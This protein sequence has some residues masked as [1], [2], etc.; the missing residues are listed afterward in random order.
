MTLQLQCRVFLLLVIKFTLKKK[1]QQSWYVKVVLVK[2]WC[3]SQTIEFIFGD[4][5]K[6]SRLV[7]EVKS[8]SHHSFSRVYIQFVLW[9]AV[10][11]ILVKRENLNLKRVECYIFFLE[12]KIG[13]RIFPFLALWELILFIHQTKKLKEHRRPE[14]QYLVKSGNTTQDR[15]VSLLLSPDVTEAFNIMPDPSFLHIALTSCLN[16][17]YCTL[18][19]LNAFLKWFLLL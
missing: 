5:P 6:S 16:A 3:I 9:W 13:E 8:S 18:K 11:L 14:L 12:R 15:R 17:L 1:I 10:K 4:N 19:G 7:V 2:S